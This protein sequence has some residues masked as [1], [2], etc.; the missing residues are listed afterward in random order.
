MALRWLAVLTVLLTA[1]SPGAGNPA[2]APATT[3]PA[4]AVPTLATATPEPPPPEQSPEQSLE[5]PTPEP[6]PAGDV[7][8]DGRPDAVTIVERGSRDSDAWRW[9]LRVRM[10]RL[11]TRTLWRDCCAMNG[12]EVGTVADVDGDGH[13]E[14][15]ASDGASATA[16]GWFLVTL[17][18]DRLVYVTGP[19]LLTGLESGA[20]RSWSCAGGGIVVTAA[21]FQGTTGTRTYYRL[22]G[23]ALVRTR[24]VRDTW[25]GA[26]A[27]PAVYDAA[28]C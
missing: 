13:A 5:Q 9:G 10:S 7:D 28:F 2:A 20:E 19:A 17:R 24:Q 18:Q 3:T 12:Q 25:G 14:V 27:R 1:C 16:R 22:A 11:G 8:G 21:A 15:A 6:P 4:S 23:T 26:T